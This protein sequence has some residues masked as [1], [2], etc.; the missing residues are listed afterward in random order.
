MRK[1]N[2]LISFVA[3][4]AA[5]RAN[6]ATFV[7]PPDRE[8]VHRADAILIGSALTSYSQRTVEGGI[9]T[10]TPFSVQEVI[11]GSE[12][13]SVI[14]VVEPGGKFDNKSTEIAGVPRFEPGQR[15]L[16]FLKA[17]GPDR[18]SAAE[19][20]LGKFRFASDISGRSL[21][22]RDEGE[23][24]GWD[25]KLQPHQERHRSAEPFLEFV[26]NEAQ[27]VTAREDYFVP[28]D[29][30]QA[31]S[32]FGPLRPSSQQ[33]RPAATATYTATSYTMTVS[34]S[35]GSRWSVFPNAVT[36][37]AGASGEPGAP[38]NGTTAVQVALAAWTNDTGS[39]VNYVYGGTDSTHTQGLH[40]P[41]GANTVLFERDL[42][43]WGVSPFTCSSTGYSGTLG[44][45]G[46]T[47]A[48]GSNVVN[49][50]T[51]VTTQEGDV[52][53]NQGIANCTLLFSNGDFNTAVT[54][55]IGHT[56]GFRH[57]DQDRASSGACSTD[58]SL[59]CA[60]VA[61]MKSFVPNGINAAL[62][63]WD[64]NAVRAVYPGSSPPPPPPPPP[65]T[66][67]SITSQPSGLT[68]GGTLSVTATNATSYQWYL[69]VSGD[70]SQP[71]SGATSSSLGAA[72]ASTTSYWVRVSNSCASV[73]SSAATVL[74]RRVPY[75][76][77]G[78]GNSDALWRNNGSGSMAIWEL[79]GRTL[80]SGNVFATITDP[81][82]RVVGVGDFNGD[83]KADILLRNASTGLVTMWLMNG[84]TIVSNVAVRVV[85][86]LAWNIEA[87]G[88]FNR[89]GRTDIVW[90]HSGTGDVA[91]WNMNG[92]TILND[93]VV[94][95]VSDTN[96]H[97]Q[98]AAD[99]TGDAWPEILW[100]NIATQQMA[101]W[102]MSNRTLLNGNVFTT[103]S[104]PAW[105]L[106]GAGDFNGDGN[107]DLLWRHSSTGT[108]AMWEMNGRTITNGGLVAQMPD[109]NW[110]VEAFGDYDANG[111]TDVL[112][113]NRATGQVLMWDLN[114]HTITNGNPVFTVSD[115]NW[116]MQPPQKPIP[117]F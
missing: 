99:F 80:V 66:A 9:E 23:I 5:L 50:E 20:V 103:L 36:F 111:R 3:A 89:D 87:L 102:E 28:S 44:V 117:G 38:G 55:E 45:G 61:V 7:V 15:I 4:F 95:R 33:L 40:A 91:I 77:F 70:A 106:M 108:V 34:G 26:R 73:D 43:S 22:V 71:I 82:T 52:E 37:F 98:L 30:L 105:S 25:S 32:V 54:H 42:S 112:W 46:I 67:P 93:A 63:P 51:F 35:M 53:L 39:N 1:L 100:R 84:R 57:S 19:L 101:M 13:R 48:S 79:Q 88:D 116:Q 29:P 27:G 17:T 18:W 115:L 92:A 85:S 113:R 96:W 10:V 107:A 49:G 78:D 90:R 60:N 65:C 64:V 94:L 2:L 41:D 62:Q 68:G 74:V 14:N 31:E 69:G 83:G 8:M 72:P 11:K 81:N 59:E 47:S 24:V 97:I 58:P 56:L 12:L 75:D 76:F 6:A 109:L 16:L 104:D 114:G 110:N 86:D 21:L